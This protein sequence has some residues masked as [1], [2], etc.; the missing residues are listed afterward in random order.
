[1]LKIKYGFRRNSMSFL[2][3]AN[4]FSN[5]GEVDPNMNDFAVFNLILL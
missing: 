1:M 4:N 5:G 2:S 3:K